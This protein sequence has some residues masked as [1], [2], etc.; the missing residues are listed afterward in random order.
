MKIIAAKYI[1][2]TLELP[3]DKSISHRAA[4]LSAMAQGNTQVQNFAASADCASTLKCLEALG[5]EINRDDST[6]VIKGVGKQGLRKPETALDCGN[7]GTTMR[8]LTGVLAGQNFDSVLV[9]DESLQKRPMKRVIDPLRLMGAEIDAEG[10]N[11][12][13]R[14]FGK[15]PLRQIDF[16]LPVASAQIKSCIMLAALNA[17]GETSVFEPTPTRDHTERML[18][19]F[20]VKVSEAV[21]N[22]VKK[23]TVSGDANLTAKDLSVPAD[24]SSAAF[25]IVAA[26]FLDGSEI[27]LPNVG[28]NPTRSAVIEVLGRL[29]ADISI[30]D[31]REICNEPVGKL[32]IT[33]K[34]SVPNGRGSNLLS[35]PVIANL[36]DEIPILAVAGTQVD[37]G[38]EIRNA[39]ELRI[40]ESDR[41]SAVV[42][43]LRKMNASVEEFED[44]LRVEKSYLKGATVDSFGDHRIAMA[45]AVAGLLADGETEILGAE[46]AA[47]SFPGFFDT[48]ADVRK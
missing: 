3:G 23:I 35:G 34:K 37:G 36:I 29:G 13:L 46:C 6:V 38:L 14:I 32:I 31:R 9:G 27:I 1:R 5:V 12:P 22:G 21:V 24:V 15:K 18:R 43:N 8:L 30:S 11:A 41:I 2:G 40:K 44:G 45:F 19:W 4:I 26:A 17:Q 48:L 39:S 42:E 7:S 16:E 10:N 25:F 28:I 47:I 20:G 33:G